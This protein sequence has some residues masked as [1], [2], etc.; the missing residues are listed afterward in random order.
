MSGYGELAASLLSPSPH[1]CCLCGKERYLGPDGLCEQCRPLIR[2][3]NEPAPPAELDGLTAGLV[4]DEPLAHAFYRFKARGETYL[5][6]FF[7]GFIRIP[8]DW[9]ADVIVPVP[10]HPLKLWARTYNQSELLAEALAKASGVPLDTGLLRR[11]KYTRAQKSRTAA[12]RRTALRGAFDAAPEVSG[13]SVI[14]VDDVVTT[15]STLTACARALKK[16]GASRVYGACA[17]AVGR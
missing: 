1:V 17:A 12:A 15:G 2:F 8:E 6:A 11:V 9:H 3:A 7:A 5:A 4:Y 16:A 13:L 10:L 14:L